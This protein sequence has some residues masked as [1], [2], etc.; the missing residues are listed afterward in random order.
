MSGGVKTGRKRGRK[1]EARM[2][3]R[4]E[5]KKKG[6]R[7]RRKRKGNKE[8]RERKKVQEKCLR[9]GGRQESLVIFLLPAIIL[10]N[11]KIRWNC[12]SWKHVHLVY[13]L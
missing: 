11:A 2:E 9:G 13:D 4:K 3:E 8:E 5:G 12:H 6:G 10:C 7:E 1:K